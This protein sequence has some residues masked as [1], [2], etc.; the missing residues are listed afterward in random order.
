MIYPKW[1]WR[2]VFT[3][4]NQVV[5]EMCRDRGIEFKLMLIRA[6][7]HPTARQLYQ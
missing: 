7:N 1:K 3:P 5:R 2:K 4:L 6:G